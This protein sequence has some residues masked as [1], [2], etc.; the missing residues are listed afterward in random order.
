MK[1]R[2]KHLTVA[3]VAAHLGI[4]VDTVRRLERIG[5][6]PLAQRDTISG[7]RIYD[8]VAIERIREAIE[9]IDSTDAR[10][11]A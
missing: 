7:Y 8:D 2:A 6:I 11:P 5:R 1:L 3:D 10:I 9:Q 4:G